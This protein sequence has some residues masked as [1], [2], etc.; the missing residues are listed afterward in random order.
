MS[1]SLRKT[2]A[3]C[4]ALLHFCLQLA[5]AVDRPDLGQELAATVGQLEA[6]PPGIDGRAT[7]WTEER[8]AQL[9][10]KIASAWAAKRAKGLA[11]KQAGTY[12]LYKF[13]DAPPEP[14]PTRKALADAVGLT[15]RAVATKLAASP[16]GFVTKTNGLR[17]VVARDEE[18]LGR[19]CQARY[20]LSGNSDDLITLPTKTSRRF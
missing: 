14:L 11:S 15:L 17:C 16:D 4:K 9:G 6:R 2:D 10:A 12:H 7:A 3:V 8:R 13:R 1:L 5:E 19:L 20:L 18:A